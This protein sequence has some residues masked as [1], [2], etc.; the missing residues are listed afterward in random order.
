MKFS[1]DGTQVAIALS[2][3]SENHQA[4]F[5]VSDQGSGI[6][7]ADKPHLFERFF[8]GDKARQRDQQTKGTGLGLSICR[9]IVQA[10]RGTIT[11]HNNSQTGCT[12]T[13]RLPA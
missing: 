2:L 5:S 11:V 1:P 3:D 6:E 4:V 8:R 9:A 10:H 12:F 13:V 7:E